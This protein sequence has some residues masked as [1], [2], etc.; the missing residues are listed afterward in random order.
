MSS[1]LSGVAGGVVGLVLIFVA[2][3]VREIL[4]LN[5]KARPTLLRYLVDRDGHAPASDVYRFIGWDELGI[6][7]G[8][9]KLGAVTVDQAPPREIIITDL[10]R[11]LL[12]SRPTMGAPRWEPSG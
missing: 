8:L 5:R 1:F 12:S 11:L 6:I 4:F 9:M 7:S 3:T 2:L 10:G